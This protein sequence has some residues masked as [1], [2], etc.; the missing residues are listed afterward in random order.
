[1]IGRAQRGNALIEFTLV[2]IPLMFLLISIFEMSRGMWMYHTLAYSLREG[3]RFVTVHGSNCNNPGNSCFVTVAQIVQRIAESSA[4]ALSPD[5]TNVTLGMY[6]IQPNSV[7]FSYGTMT[8]AMNPIICNPMRSC[9][10]SCS[11]GCNANR[12]A[13][14]P[15]DPANK[16]GGADI[17]ITGTVRFQS[18]IAMF[19]PGAGPGINYPTF[20]LPASSRDTMRF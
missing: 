17:V 13:N 18:A 14:W 12:G 7:L 11:S 8:G 9:L 19:W 4:G 15:Q 16:A 5:E 6:T 3:T 2:G 10:A 1:M 20:N